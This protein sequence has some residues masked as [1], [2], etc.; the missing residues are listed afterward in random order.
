[1]VAEVRSSVGL[2][3][4]PLQFLAHPVVEVLALL[5]ESGLDVDANDACTV[6]HPLAALHAISLDDVS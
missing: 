4:Q 2:L 5:G 6:G 3:V 1:M